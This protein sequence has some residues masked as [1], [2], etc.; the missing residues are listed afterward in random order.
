ML[1]VDTIIK[2]EELSAKMHLLA[3]KYGWSKWLTKVNVTES[4]VTKPY[5]EMYNQ[6]S[7]DLVAEHFAED[8]A[9]FNYEYTI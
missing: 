7:I 9:M 5:H 1:K 6:E 2:T 3:S 8:I 4:D